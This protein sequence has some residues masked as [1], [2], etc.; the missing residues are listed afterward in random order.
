MS[1]ADAA[2]RAVAARQN[3]RCF[4]D[5]EVPWPI[6]SCST[7]PRRRDPAA[8][9]GVFRDSFGAKENSGL[10]KIRGHQGTSRDAGRA[11]NL[12]LI[13]TLSFDN[14]AAIAAA[15]ASAEERPP[16]PTCPT[17]P[18]VASRCIS[19][20]QPRVCAVTTK[21]CSHISPA[22]RT[23]PSAL[24]CEECLKSGSRWLHLRICRTCGHVGCCDDSPNKHATAHFHATLIR[25]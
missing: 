22:C 12:H 11:V 19:R 10:A 13:A 17:S 5:G 24:G 9:D 8:F 21:G 20:K 14:M 1:G 15:F 18:A 6:S 23:T 2:E 25:D 16:L 4:I 3:D 7:R